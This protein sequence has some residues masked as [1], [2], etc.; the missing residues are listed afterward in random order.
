[1]SIQKTEH[2]GEIKI[3]KSATVSL[4]V[5][6]WKIKNWASEIFLNKILNRISLNFFMI[7]FTQ[8]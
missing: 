2:Q 5:F 7:I 6:L 3:N 1:M 8:I 4:I